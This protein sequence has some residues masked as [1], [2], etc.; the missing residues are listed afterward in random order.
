[1]YVEH[2]FTQ[3]PYVKKEAII[4]TTNPPTPQ[5]SRTRF[6]SI[7]IKSNRGPK[8]GRAIGSRA[9][10]LNHGIAAI[11]AG[12]G[13]VGR[14]VVGVPGLG[15]VG[16]LEE[17]V[18]AGAVVP[19]GARE[20]AAVGLGPGRGLD[21]VRGAVPYQRRQAVVRR[22]AVV[23]RVHHVRLAV[24]VEPRGPLVD[25][26]PALLPRLRRLRYHPDGALQG[27]VVV[28]Q[29]LHAQ[30]LVLYSVE[31]RVR[32]V[33]APVVESHYRPVDGPCARQLPC[34]REIVPGGCAACGW[35]V[36]M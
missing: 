19:V 25:R 29:L 10:D 11:V 32:Q 14:G 6:R 13:A 12:A 23:G 7:E 8:V 20:E 30:R 4:K 31:A 34:V 21:R 36:N 16:A 9:H 33:V 26:R 18:V 28:S 35:F 17:A 2:N 1:M 15:A 5:K 27:D 22:P 24:E 3:R